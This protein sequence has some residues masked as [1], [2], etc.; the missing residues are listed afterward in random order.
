MHSSGNKWSLQ[1]VIYHLDSN[2]T[3]DNSLSETNIK[4]QLKIV[5]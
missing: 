2:F 5:L 3:L 1:A 4:Y